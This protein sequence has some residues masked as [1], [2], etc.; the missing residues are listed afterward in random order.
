M[1]LETHK[2]FM[3]PET[4]KVIMTQETH[5]FATLETLKVATPQGQVTVTPETVMADLKVAGLTPGSTENTKV[6]EVGATPER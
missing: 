4:H 5:K 3:T 6:K 2:V 1:T